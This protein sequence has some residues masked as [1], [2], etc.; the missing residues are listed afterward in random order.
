MIYR[1]I[2]QLPVDYVWISQ[3]YSAKKPH[4]G[5][6][7]GYR[8]DNPDPPVRAVADGKVAIKGTDQYGGLYVV[9]RHKDMIEG[10]WVYTCYW[11][12]A[13]FA[14]GYGKGDTVKRGSVLGIMGKSGNAS[15]KHLHFEFWVSPQNVTFSASNRAKHAADP[16][17]YLFAHKGQTVSDKSPSIKHLAALDYKAVSMAGRLLQ[18]KAG[19]RYRTEPSARLGVF[20]S[21]GTL[22]TG[23]YAVAAET[24]REIDGYTWVQ[25]MYE[26]RTAWAAVVTGYNA[27]QAD[28]SDPRDKEIASLKERLQAAQKTVETGNA[29]IQALQKRI[30]AARKELGD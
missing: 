27:L 16:A 10:K 30:A 7:I 6:D 14:A 19:V 3:G 9:L 12:L 8:S 29:Q 23:G 5:I 13:S 15:G 11:H 17:D 28:E 24:D 20:S 4:Y 1:D 22:P 25:L 2:P 21:L 26:G 18:T